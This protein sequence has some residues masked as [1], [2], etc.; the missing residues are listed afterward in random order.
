MS[1]P[2]HIGT[3]WEFLC[4]RTRATKRRV[5]PRAIGGVAR[6][7]AVVLAV[8]VLCLWCDV[9]ADVL[10]LNVDISCGLICIRAYPY[11]RWPMLDVRVVPRVPSW[12][13]PGVTW[14]HDLLGPCL[15]VS[16]WLLLSVCLGMLAGLK[17]VLWRRSVRR[18]SE[19][20][21]RCRVCGYDSRWTT[22][23]R[24]PECGTLR[25]EARIGKR[26]GIARWAYGPVCAGLV[27]VCAVSS[28]SVSAGRVL[29][30][31]YGG[32]GSL[33][34][35]PPLSLHLR[36]NLV[37][38]SGF[39]WWYFKI[40]SWDGGRGISF[41]S[42][43]F[44]VAASLSIVVYSE[45]RRSWSYWRRTGVAGAEV[46]HPCRLPPSRPGGGGAAGD[47]GA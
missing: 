10:W 26:P 31:S 21:L 42:W 41:P 39:V 15:Y 47:S 30:S 45:A 11:W 44:A 19:A 32:Y 3:A 38:S 1:R 24:C 29:C 33:D 43:F 16:E 37:R 12:D 23:V 4:D 13:W 40:H 20:A 9:W 35:G 34:L 17:C 2:R 28:C 27:L 5:C 7:L 8:V 36:A 14:G 18:A 46:V 22:S 25:G 6:W